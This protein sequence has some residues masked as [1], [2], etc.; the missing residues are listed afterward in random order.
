MKGI[1]HFIIIGF[2]GIII[3]FTTVSAQ[4]DCATSAIQTNL[5]NGTSVQKLLEDCS[6]LQTINFIG[7]NFAGGVIVY[8][9]PG[10]NGT[11]IIAANSDA[12]SNATWYNLLSYNGGL[13]NGSLQEGIGTGASNMNA[14]CAMSGCGKP[15]KTN[16]SYG[17]PNNDALYFVSSSNRG[18]Y[19]DWYLPSAF[20]LD[21]AYKAV[22]SNFPSCAS[23]GYWTSSQIPANYPFQGL[24]S[25][26]IKDTYTSS[27][28]IID[29]NGNLTYS[30]KSSGKCARAFRTFSPWIDAVDP[31]IQIGSALAI[32]GSN[33][34]TTL[35][36]NVI[37]F[38]NGISVHPHESTEN[39]MTV[40]VPPGTHDG[41]LRIV[42]NGVQSNTV[43]IEIGAAPSGNPIVESFSVR[44]VIV[45]D[46]GF[47]NTRVMTVYGKNFSLNNTVTFGG[48]AQAVSMP[49]SNPNQF[50]VSIPENVKTGRI[51]VTSSVGHS[52]ASSDSLLVFK[53]STPTSDTTTQNLYEVTIS[54][55]KTKLVAV[56]EQSNILTSD[57]GG[58]NWHFANISTPSVTNMSL[59]TAEFFEINGTELIAI[60]GRVPAV[61]LENAVNYQ[62]YTTAQTL[63]NYNPRTTAFEITKLHGANNQLFAVKGYTDLVY[64]NGTSASNNA[65]NFST[66]NSSSELFGIANNDSTILSVGLMST[67][68]LKSPLRTSKTAW[69]TNN[70]NFKLTD[71]IWADSLFVG[72]GRQSHTNR[73]NSSIYHSTDGSTWNA[74]LCGSRNCTTPTKAL[75]F[76]EKL[77]LFFTAGHLL[78]YYYSF[79]GKSWVET[80]LPSMYNTHITQVNSIVSTMD[81]FV[82]VGNGGLIGVLSLIKPTH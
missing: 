50:N 23:G 22:S 58:S 39:T 3:P 24:T 27:V 37:Q 53:Y 66:V 77:D 61:N 32:Q 13:F 1:K 70:Q 62:L 16:L 48:G 8:L 9:D 67:S 29:N 30:R 74:S 17:S 51:A 42:V 21:T 14:A 55:D 60:F 26:Q 18:G 11:G 59:K 7:K 25:Y 20:E 63:T 33:F 81:G 34:D 41:D 69:S 12:N 15:P 6:T 56:G 76:N 5:N 36:N 49:S 44:M 46:N 79:D 52:S 75:A 35:T 57:N 45:Y 72:V 65:F 40:I 47:I 64:Y 28:Y 43:Q 73:Y 71:V 38:P 82:I 31:V 10:R 4:T 19:S 68:F 2:I 78:K 54:K 80:I